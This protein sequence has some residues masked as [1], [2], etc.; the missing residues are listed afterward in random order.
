MNIYKIL[1]INSHNST[2]LNILFVLKFLSLLFL[3]GLYFNIF[4]KH[5]RVSL[6]PNGSLK[7]SCYIF[8]N[9]HL[10]FYLLQIIN[11]NRDSTIDKQSPFWKFNHCQLAKISPLY[12]DW[13][14]WDPWNKK[15]VNYLSR[16]E[17]LWET[18][19]VF[20][21]S[22]RQLLLYHKKSFL[23]IIRSYFNQ[24][25]IL[26][27]FLIRNTTFLLK[28]LSRVNAAFVYIFALWGNF[29]NKTFK[30]LDFMLFL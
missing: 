11:L 21:N 8:F 5:L 19:A 4:K 13:L 9:V 10:S 16:V 14:S 20:N 3:R 27:N 25:R 24:N 12:Q 30:M 18:F 15:R 6:R 22:T 28:P 23:E 29:E 26:S 7:L 1:N 2:S 17:F